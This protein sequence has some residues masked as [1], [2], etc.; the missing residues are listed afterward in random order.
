MPMLTQV[1]SRVPG[2]CDKSCLAIQACVAAGHHA[3]HAAEAGVCE[4]KSSCGRMKM[5]TFSWG[6]IKT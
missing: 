1:P 3:G 5:E 6:C 2:C 4:L